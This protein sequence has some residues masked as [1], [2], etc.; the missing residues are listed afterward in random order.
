MSE[1]LADWH[2]YYVLIGN[3]GAVLAGLVF[4]AMTL[5][6]A[7]AAPE[8]SVARVTARQIF[9]NFIGMVF[10]SLVMLAPWRDA[11]PFGLTVAAASG[12]G[13]ALSVQRIRREG[14]RGLRN[15]LIVA[16]EALVVIS[17][18]GIALGMP[19]AYA[20]VGVG[21]GDIELLAFA[22]TW[23]LVTE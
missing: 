3:V 8:R 17:G 23:R 7:L 13:L 12:F 20:G 5:R 19:Y 18:L 10:I 14:L 1:S 15:D 21:T 16:G 22:A 9:G 2:D 11:L 6:P 4:V